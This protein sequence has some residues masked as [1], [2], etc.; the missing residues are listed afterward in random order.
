MFTAQFPEKFHYSDRDQLIDVSKGLAILLVIIGHTYQNRFENY[1]DF[2]IF[3]VIYSFHMPLFVFLSGAVSSIS[4][5]KHDQKSSSKIVFNAFWLQIKRLCKRL[6]VPFISWTIIGYYISHRN[7][8]PSDFLFKVIVSPDWSLWFLVCIF[9]CNLF[10][11]LIRSLLNIITLN[12]RN[13]E[14]KNSLYK[15]IESSENITLLLIFIIW[16]II[17]KNMPNEY[18]LVFAKKYF[19]YFVLG[20]LFYKILLNPIFQRSMPI[21][22]VMFTISSPFWHRA[23]A[24][25]LPPYFQNYRDTFDVFRSFKYLVAITGIFSSIDLMRRFCNVAS[26]LAVSVLGLCGRLSLGIYAIHFYFIPLNPPVISALCVSVVFVYIIR[27]TR[28]LRLVLL[29]EIKA[30]KYKKC[31]KNSLIQNSSEAIN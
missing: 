2:A 11:S 16:E 10:S 15:N 21:F 30:K 8:A 18:G 6:L 29:G 28:Y 12:F 4:S 5:K 26:P 23:T 3:R 24:F 27:K 7:L 1:D 25:N 14:K 17:S 20:S 9:Y 13:F 22:Y 31:R 19:F